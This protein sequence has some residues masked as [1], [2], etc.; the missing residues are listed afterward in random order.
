MESI[1]ALAKKDIAKM[2]AFGIKSGPEK[3][4]VTESMMKE[5]SIVYFE[6][7]VLIN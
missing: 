5:D 6:D 7:E 4:K 3:E 2:S 1:S